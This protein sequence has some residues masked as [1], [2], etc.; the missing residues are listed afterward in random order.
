MLLL[1]QRFRQE[2][3]DG[4]TSKIVIERL[5]FAAA[6]RATEVGYDNGSSPQQRQQHHVLQGVA[7]GVVEL[8][9]ATAHRNGTW[10]QQ[11][12]CQQSADCLQASQS[13]WSL[14]C[15]TASMADS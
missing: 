12:V 15:R 6:S 14:Q 13:P 11:H 1:N 8:L 10:D 3:A 2:N 4:F 5:L 7:Q 9:Q